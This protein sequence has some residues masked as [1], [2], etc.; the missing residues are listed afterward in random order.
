MLQFLQLSIRDRDTWIARS[1]KFAAILKPSQVAD[2]QKA[3]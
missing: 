2:P 1:S 3:A